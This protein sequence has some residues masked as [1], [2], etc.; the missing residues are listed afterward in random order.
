MSVAA[1]TERDLALVDAIAERV[2]E[3]LAERA[4]RPRLVTAAELAELLGVKR[5]W[6]YEH[7]QE[8]GAQALGAGDRPRLRFDVDRALSA[9]QTSEGSQAPGSPEGSQPTRHRRRR[10]AGSD[11]PQL[12][13]GGR[14]AR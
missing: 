4:A 2:L 3:L 13:I 11:V 10:G 1:L 6:V 7:A 8:L 14:R 9:R 12:P 5:E